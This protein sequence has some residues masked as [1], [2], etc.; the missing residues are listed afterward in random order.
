[1]NVLNSNNKYN[2]AVRELYAAGEFIT[3]EIVALT[4]QKNIVFSYSSVWKQFHL[5]LLLYHYTNLVMFE[6]KSTVMHFP[7]AI[8]IN[9]SIYINTLFL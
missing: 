2:H 9:S 1:M 8:F 6:V 4:S 7:N 5:H 3:G